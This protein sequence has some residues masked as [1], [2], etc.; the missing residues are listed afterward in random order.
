[1]KTKTKM[2]Q[3]RYLI[4]GFDVYEALPY[5]HM[6]VIAVATSIKKA[7]EMIWL[8]LPQSDGQRVVVKSHKS[9]LTYTQLA[10]RL[11]DYGTAE[12]ILLNA[13]GNVIDG[14]KVTTIHPNEIITP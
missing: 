8:S 2:K 12:L 9:E 6:Y 7:L 3:R 11:H 5:G 14:I 1:M 13:G 4:V 10:H